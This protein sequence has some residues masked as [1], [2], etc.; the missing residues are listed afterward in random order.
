MDV[1]NIS[2]WK[3][4][5]H[6]ET[7]EILKGKEKQRHDEYYRKNREKVL[8]RQK[9]ADEIRDRKTYS[10]QYYLDHKEKIDAVNK[11]RYYK[12]LEERRAKALAH[13]YEHREEILKRRKEL[14]DARKL[15]DVPVV[16]GEGQ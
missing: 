5:P 7:D 15:R 12:N 10:R 8:R 14:R 4:K 16:P 6:E 9:K 13:Y 3:P 2:I 1:K 11:E